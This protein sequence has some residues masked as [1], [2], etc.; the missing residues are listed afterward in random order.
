MLGMNLDKFITIFCKNICCPLKSEQLTDV[1]CFAVLGLG[2]F[3]PNKEKMISWDRHFFSIIYSIYNEYRVTFAWKRRG[4]WRLFP[5]SNFPSLQSFSCSTSD[6]HLFLLLFPDFNFY[7]LL[8]KHPVSN[9][10]CPVLYSHRFVETA[11]P[12][13]LNR[14]WDFAHIWSS[15]IEG[16]RHLILHRSSTASSLWPEWRTIHIFMAYKHICWQVS[17]TSLRLAYETCRLTGIKLTCN[18]APRNMFI[19]LYFP[20]EKLN[21]STHC[22]ADEWIPPLTPKSKHT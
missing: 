6:P 7:L 20:M 8:T 22:T 13:L 10:K 9:K 14:Y 12:M 16:A 2:F 4:G 19:A 11:P 5:C 17:R 18:L 21:I 1:Q 3:L 15:G